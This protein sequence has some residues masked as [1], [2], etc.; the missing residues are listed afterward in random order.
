MANQSERGQ[1]GTGKHPHKDSA[2]P[3]PHTKETGGQHRGDHGGE[4]GGQ[5]GQSGSESRDGGGDDLKSREYRDA[6]GNVHHHTHT[7]REQQGK[8]GSGR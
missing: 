1:Q 7:S 5:G 2:E 8:G 3:Y 4:R 6:Q